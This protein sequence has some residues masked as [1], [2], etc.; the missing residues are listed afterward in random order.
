MPD[1]LG[2]VL[3]GVCTLL[4][5][6]ILRTAGGIWRLLTRAVHGGGSGDAGARALASPSG[7]PVSYLHTQSRCSTATRGDPTGGGAVPT[8]AT[9]QPEQKLPGVPVSAIEWEL[10]DSTELDVLCALKEW[11]ARADSG[12]LDFH[13]IPHDLLVCFLRGYS[14]RSDWARA[15]FAY[16]HRAMRWRRKER[17]ETLMLA[18]MEESEGGHL[19]LKRAVF[20]RLFPS[21]PIGVDA[22]GHPVILERPCAC[23]PAELQRQFSREAF[24]RHAAYSRECIR[25]Y[26][27]LA[28]HR[29][30]RRIYKVVFILDIAGLSFAHTES[31]AIGLLRAYNASFSDSYPESVARILVINAPVVFSVVFSLI[32]PFLHPVTVSKLSVC[33]SHYA[34]SLRE[35]GIT[36]RAE[37]GSTVPDATPSWVAEMREVRAELPADALERGYL[38]AAD[39][40]AM[41][42][43]GLL[44]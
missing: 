8:V 38:P 14:Y 31:G 32:R 19:P 20:E 33:S 21:G 25:A 43:R 30:G 5:L 17:I 16:L 44:P 6:L 27:S 7:S 13:A 1:P 36:L 18:S 2:A 35:H 11:A 23:H 34:A 42:D 40:D 22:E 9:I 37:Y 15:S 39:A 3:M 28:S 12:G 41:R 4:L 10:L 26:L 24:L 29:A